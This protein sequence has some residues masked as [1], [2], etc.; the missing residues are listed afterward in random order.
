M[1]SWEEN[2]KVI[3]S[4]REEGKV[5]LL[6]PKGIEFLPKEK[7]IK[8]RK[9]RSLSEDFIKDIQREIQGLPAP[10]KHFLFKKK[11]KSFSFSYVS[12]IQD[13]FLR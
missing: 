5:P 13:S 8:V 4:M 9:E 1:A 2:P 11:K 10:E 7:A 12:T 6:S 3:A